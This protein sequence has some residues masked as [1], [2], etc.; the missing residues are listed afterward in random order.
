MH[1]RLSE[2]LLVA[3]SNK[4]DIVNPLERSNDTQ[5][6]PGLFLVSNAMVYLITVP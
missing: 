4:D 1:Y 3:I 5:W 6:R 2:F